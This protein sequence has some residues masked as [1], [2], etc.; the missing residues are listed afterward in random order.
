MNVLNLVHLNPELFKGVRINMV[1]GLNYL[2]KRS[3][4]M[5]YNEQLLDNYRTLFQY[6]KSEKS[7]GFDYEYDPSFEVY[8]ANDYDS[9]MNIANGIYESGTQLQGLDMEGR[10]V[11][12]LDAKLEAIDAMDDLLKKTRSQLYNKLNGN[13]VRLYDDHS[14]KEWEMYL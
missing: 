7:N 3:T 6:R 2:Q 14:S 9:A 8:F 13:G 12:D 1:M 11:D 10:V 5:T 4:G